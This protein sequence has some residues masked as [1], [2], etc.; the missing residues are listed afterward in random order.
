MTRQARQSQ[1]SRW[2]FSLWLALGVAVAF[3]T[4]AFA[5]IVIREA[6]TGKDSDNRKVALQP[7]GAP[8]RSTGS[9]V[10]VLSPVPGIASEVS[11]ASQ[12]TERLS[13]GVRHDP[14]GALSSGAASA[15]I[16]AASSPA[17]LPSQPVVKSVTPPPAPPPPPPAPPTAPPM[18]FVA[19]GSIQGTQ[20]T[21]GQPV[22][23]IRRQD[24][25][26]VVRAGDSIGQIYRVESIS[27]QTIDFIYL[28]LMQ[29]Q[30]LVLAP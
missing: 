30:V 19:V 1:G 11:L 7:G 26:I 17:A 22:A 6:A 21:N 2:K 9:T 4:T 23:F 13:G 29:R 18:P 15:P 3:I 27:P 28:P 12:T 8:F 5:T 14:F 16:A 24:E 20:L 10:A 25:L